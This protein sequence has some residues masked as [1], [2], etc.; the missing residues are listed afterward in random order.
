MF[1]NF[2]VFSSLFSFEIERTY[3]FEGWRPSLVQSFSSSLSSSSSHPFARF[4][5]ADTMHWPYVYCDMES[6]SVAGRRIHRIDEKLNNCL[7]MSIDNARMPQPHLPHQTWSIFKLLR[8]FPS[9]SSSFSHKIL[10]FS[11]YIEHWTMHIKSMQ[12]IAWNHFALFRGFRCHNISTNAF[13][14]L[15]LRT[16]TSEHTDDDDDDD[17]LQWNRM[18]ENWIRINRIFR[19]KFYSFLKKR[20]HS[21]HPI[22]RYGMKTAWDRCRM[23]DDQLTDLIWWKHWESFV[24]KCDL[25]QRLMSSRCYESMFR[26]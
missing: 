6:S 12:Q 20:I 23:A 5:F 8:F 18:A 21:S 7:A 4:V 2:V 22:L 24:D 14:I 13:L 26:I 16:T 11:L 19:F 3:L 17:Y 25:L 9:S 1:D 10:C 15:Y